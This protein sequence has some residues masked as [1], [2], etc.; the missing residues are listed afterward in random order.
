MMAAGD[1]AKASTKT[2]KNRSSALDYEWTPQR[3]RI[4]EQKREAYKLDFLR[5]AKECVK[6]VD[7][8][9]PSGAK[10]VKFEPAPS[11]LDL[12]RLR[13]EIKRFNIAYSTRMHA[14]D[15]SYPVSELPIEIICL[16]ARKVFVSTLIELLAFHRCEFFDHTNAL[17]MAHEAKASKNVAAMGHRVHRNWPNDTEPPLR[18]RITRLSDELIEW[19]PGWESRLVVMTAGSGGASSASFTYHFMHLSE[20]PKYPDGNVEVANAEQ[21]AATFREIYWE[22]TADGQGDL[23]HEGWNN[24]LWI[25]DLWKCLDE[26]RP[27]P[28]TW[29][30]KVRW[31][32]AWWQDPHYRIPALPAE[33]T[34]IMATLSDKEKFLMEHCYCDVA[35]LKWRRQKIRGECSKQNKMPAEEYFNQEYPSSPEEAFVSVG[36]G[37]FDKLKLRVMKD[38]AEHDRPKLY[39]LWREAL[40]DPANRDAEPIINFRFDEAPYAE[41]ANFFQWE[42]PR[43]GSWYVIGADVAEGLPHGDWSVATIFDRTDGRGMR[44]VARFIGK[45]DPEEFG[46]LIKFLAELYNDAFVNCERNRDGSATN[47]KLVKSGYP[48]LYHGRNEEMFRN[49]ENPEAFTAGFITSP[50]TKR[51]LV[52]R[53]VTALKDD[54]I[55][56][57]HPVA[58]QQWMDFRRRPDSA[59]AY[60]A[61]A[62]RNDDCTMADLLAVWAHEEGPPVV[63]PRLLGAVED[64]EGPEL[65][66]EE[67]R[68]RQLRDGLAKVIA[69]AREKNSRELETRRAMAGFAQGAKLVDIL[70]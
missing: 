7:R 35:Q 43:K 38:R 55:Q 53:G 51:L 33:E 70:G 50:R 36:L 25:G 67:T 9:D 19:D 57:R 34:D 69:R 11:Q 6:I 21:A 27:F 26:G 68:K 30:R 58:I 17:V 40:P 65:S 12:L 18:N 44:E 46:E 61:P 59:D 2:S 10:L 13:E 49:E 4:R 24:A 48:F 5:W 41:G 14:I 45:L 63:G 16:K 42:A 28:P 15:P 22:A 20:V 66:P 37:V 3:L 39:N 1:S 23:F 47:I 31:F 54:H 62:G 64:A 8:D 32:W 52:A 60:G 56:L 29:N